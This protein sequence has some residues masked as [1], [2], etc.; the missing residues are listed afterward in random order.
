MVP[1]K[2]NVKPY[3]NR[4]SLVFPPSIRDFL[5]EGHRAAVMEDIVESLDLS[6]FYAKIPPVG[7]PSYD[8]LMMVKILTY[9]YMQ[10]IRSSRRIARLLETDVAFI[11]LAGMQKPDFRTLCH[12]RRDNSE[13]LKGLM[14]NVV[15]LCSDLGMIGLKHVAT[16]GTV[17]K[18]NASAGKMYDEKK[19]EKEIAKILGEADAEDER[20]DELY[21]PD[22]RG[23][24]L[25]E[26]IRDRAARLKKIRE[27]KEKLD[28]KKLERG[29]V[30]EEEDKEK[31]SGNGKTDKGKKINATDPDAEF[32]KAWGRHVVGYRMECMT[33]EREGVIVACDVTNDKRDTRHLIPLLNQMETT[34]PAEIE[35]VKQRG[36]SIALTAD[37]GFCSL[38]NLRELEKRGQYDGYIPDQSYQSYQR[39]KGR[40]T[41]NKVDFRYHAEGDYYECPD[42]AILKKHVET[43]DDGKK[44]TI[45]RVAE[46]D[47][48][49]RCR[50]FGQ[51]TDSPRGRAVWRYED[52]ALKE[53]MRDKLKSE[54]G[55]AIY[56]RR[57]MVAE[58]SFADKKEK[59]GFRDFLLRGLKGVKC[60]GLWMT[61]SFNVSRI[62]YYIKRR[63]VKLKDALGGSLDIRG[64]EC[65]PVLVA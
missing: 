27:V 39:N 23:D 12:F 16:D 65:V 11:Y 22:K 64:E 40:D 32:Q 53:K 33:D 13:Q 29:N 57:K 25:P 34:L 56:R 43:T 52:D 54:K 63:G 15:R 17:V 8:P 6:E 37:S 41:F 14:Q 28:K 21:G 60:E 44:V 49:K 4:Q 2:P 24:E 50:H 19:L 48:C 3:D 5:P 42:G 31:Q 62:I 45:Y 38:E 55:R 58:K 59:M 30:D 1:K 61:I 36:E 51:C 26:E 20:E 35:A 10:G 18:G 46:E 47:R 9:A 7:N